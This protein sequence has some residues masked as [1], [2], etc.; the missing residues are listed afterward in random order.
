[1]KEDCTEK[2]APLLITRTKGRRVEK[3]DKT[4]EE[5]TTHWRECRA[6]L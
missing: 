6:G 1:M 2:R 3:G 4:G 5:A